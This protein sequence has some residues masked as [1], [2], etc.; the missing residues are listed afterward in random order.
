MI[1]VGAQY[2][3]PP[4]P[5]RSD[6]SRDLARM[7]DYGFNT[8]K[9]W[10]CWSW[11]NPEPGRFDFDDIDELMDLSAAHELAVVLNTILENCPYWLEARHPEARYVDNEDR[12][13]PLAAA[14][15]TPGGGW[16]GLCFDNNHVW[17]AGQ[18][19]LA[20][21][22][23]R[24]RGHEAL[25]VWD[26]WNEPHMEPASYFPD[27]WYCYCPASQARFRS[28]LVE[29]YG[30][31]A[32]LNAQWSRRFGSWDEVHPPRLFES[33]PDVIDWREFWF[34]NLRRWL[35][36]RASEVR[37]GDPG[38]Q[39]MTHVAL[40]GYTGQLATHT[41]DEHLF[42]DVADIF[43]TSSFPQWLM[44]NDP[45]EH[46]FN[47][48]AVRSA[49]GTRPY[50]QAEL[51]GGKGRR[52]GAKS[53]PHPS[54]DDIALWMWDAA[55]SGASGVMFWQWRPELLGPESPGYGL[56]AP[57]GGISPRLTSAS[58]VARD[59]L[60]GPLDGMTLDPARVGV[61]VS[62]RTALHA[63]AT[64]RSIEIYTRAAMGAFRLLADQDVHVTLSHEEALGSTEAPTALYW[65]M[66][67]VCSDELASRLAR[68]V[69]QGGTLVAEASPG[70]HD[71]N[72]RHRP[73]WPEGALG[74]L[75]GARVVDNEIVPGTVVSLGDGSLAGEWRADC[76]EVTTAEPIGYF[77][78][79]TVGTTLQTH[80]AGRAILVGTYPSLHYGTHR[81][82]TTR[83]AVVNLL[84]ATADE[85]SAPAAWRQPQ[86]G[87]FSRYGVSA[88]GEP[89]V[90]FLN[91]TSKAQAVDCRTS[92]MVLGHGPGEH[93]P[94]AEGPG[95]VLVPSHGSVQMIVRDFS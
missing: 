54:G 73:R 63:F 78:D 26:V 48:E 2:Y 14:M 62:R 84:G 40:S 41:I 4:N 17:A 43:G 86:P 16:P 51:Q 65:P 19:F 80:G 47:L 15:N 68:Y 91:W 52:E 90:I 23:D 20:A 44:G 5:P 71:E 39:V 74:D 21:L 89:L 30:D 60:S 38:H 24:Y 33:V 3:R 34:Q 46:L 88:Q 35:A 53:T 37:S 57:D 27:R 7:R 82:G 22:T 72:G 36:L 59:L 42:A 32:T 83:N 31:V 13:V 61:L 76:L 58:K 8:V 75:F 94:V 50:W 25:S 11:M 79:G 87:L 6:W 9:L 56:C 12:P 49:A 45:V 64:D 1:N 81:D 10:C 70:E 67:T 85:R 18:E 55:A 93:G 92:C 28:W 66:P 29:R 77:A 95:E 69:E